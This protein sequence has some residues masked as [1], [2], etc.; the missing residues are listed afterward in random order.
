MSARERILA[1][2]AGGRLVRSAELQARAACHAPQI[3]RLLSDPDS[4]IRQF[5]GAY[6]LAEAELPYDEGYYETAL[7][8]PRGVLAGWGAARWWGMT[9]TVSR[10][11]APDTVLIPAGDWGRSRIY[12]AEVVATRN[13]RLLETGIERIDLAP[14]LQL[15]ITS[16]VRTFCD[17]FAARGKDGHTSSEWFYEVLENFVRRD[18]ANTVHEAVLTARALGRNAEGIADILHSARLGVGLGREM[19]GSY[20]HGPR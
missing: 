16:P 6:A 8:F 9:E 1:T 4:P 12:S 11:L 17:L 10:D 7:R 3:A 5:A 19:E 15:R 2:L 20:A 13:S 14:G 18:E